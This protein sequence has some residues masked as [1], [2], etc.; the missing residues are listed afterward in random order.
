MLYSR[1]LRNCSCHF[2]T[3]WKAVRIL[4]E[5]AR[6][7]AP[8]VGRNHATPISRCLL[9]RFCSCQITRASSLSQAIVRNRV[10][11]T[12]Q[13]IYSAMLGAYFLGGATPE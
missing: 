5:V 11:M 9:L 12:L 6:R 10:S 13:L 8:R 4:V 3:Y 7:D 2:Q 1:C